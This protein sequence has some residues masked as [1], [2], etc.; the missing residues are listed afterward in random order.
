MLQGQVPATLSRTWGWQRTLQSGELPPRKGRTEQSSAQRDCGHPTLNEEPGDKTLQHLPSTNPPMQH[1]LHRACN[2]RCCAFCPQ[3]ALLT[4]HR[5]QREICCPGWAAPSS[6][7][8]RGMGGARRCRHAAVPH[9]EGNAT[10]AERDMQHSAHNHRHPNWWD[11]VSPSLGHGPGR[12]LRQ[13]APLGQAGGPRECCREH[14]PQ[15]P[16]TYKP[17]NKNV[18]LPGEVEPANPHPLPAQPAAAVLCRA[19]PAAGPRFSPASP[20]PLSP[21]FFF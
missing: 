14:Q 17:Q 13:A 6:C 2:T 19:M 4:L 12:L 21:L 10:A 16:P 18:G 1:L 9:R 5:F 8:E 20:S 7:C 15:L 11:L 3:A